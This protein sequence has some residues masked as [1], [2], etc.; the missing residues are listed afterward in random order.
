MLDKIRSFATTTSAPT[1]LGGIGA[2]ALLAGILARQP[3]NAGNGNESARRFGAIFALLCCVLGV[4]AAIG[5]LAANDTNPTPGINAGLL[6]ATVV[7]IISTAFLFV[8]R[9]IVSH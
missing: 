1:L 9:H 2:C 6:V 3:T 7:D 5:A 4:G 8:R